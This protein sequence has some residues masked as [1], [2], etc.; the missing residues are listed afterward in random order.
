MLA[1]GEISATI[2]KTFLT[3]LAASN[4]ECENVSIKFYFLVLLKIVPSHQKLIKIPQR[5]PSLPAY[6][7]PCL[8]T[9]NA[10]S[11]DFPYN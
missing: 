8:V 6:I 3:L 1:A 11:A 4:N 2:M 10:I 9:D 5:V 7:L